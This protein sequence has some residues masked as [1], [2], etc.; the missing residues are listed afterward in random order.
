MEADKRRIIVQEIQQWR[1]GKLL[2]DHYCDFLLNLYADRESDSAEDETLPTKPNRTARAAYAAAGA[3]GW[4]WLLFFA[5]FSLFFLIVLHFN[6]FHPAMQIAIPLL[7]TGGFLTIGAVLRPRS[8]TA[9]MAWTG[10][11]M[12]L[13]VGSVI[14]LMR[15]HAVEN[16]SWNVLIWSLCAIFWVVYGIWQ[17]IPLL[18]FCGWICLALVYSLLLNRLADGGSMWDKQVYWLPLAVLFGWSGWFIRRWSKQACTVLLAVCA[19]LVL[20]PEVT[21]LVENASMVWLQGLFVGKL[22]IGGGL[23]FLLRKYWIEWVA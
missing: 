1:K 21:M 17:R 18:H 15:L 5:L 8:E 7:L 3:A 4:K 13:L 11:G 9:G 19:L 6:A 12:L 10:A 14:Y 16:W 22:V 23:L 2:P 20:M